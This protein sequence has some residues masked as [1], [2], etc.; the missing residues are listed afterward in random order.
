MG[1]TK[2]TLYKDTKSNDPIMTCVYIKQGLIQL[3]TFQHKLI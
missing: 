1:N 3:A 2:S